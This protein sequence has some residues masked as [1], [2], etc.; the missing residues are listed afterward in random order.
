MAP[1]RHMAK[2]DLEYRAK[3]SGSQD[4]TVPERTETKST[5]GQLDR[6]DHPC[7]PCLKEENKACRTTGTKTDKDKGGE[8]SITSAML[9]SATAKARL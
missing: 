8:L 2:K 4:W 6:P 9:N 1:S 3:S 5:G 7:L